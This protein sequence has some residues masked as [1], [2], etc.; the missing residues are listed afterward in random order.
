[1]CNA[2]LGLPPHAPSILI[3][4]GAIFLPRAYYAAWRV[5]YCIKPGALDELGTA[6]P[7]HPYIKDLIVG[8]AQLLARLKPANATTHHRDLL[9]EINIFIP[10]SHPICVHR[11]PQA[12]VSNSERLELLCP[13][14]FVLLI[15]SDTQRMNLPV[16]IDYEH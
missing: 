5:V 14:E 16:F 10:S 3:S 7:L 2:I 1:M 13:A 11:V 6:N 12:L 9:N 15:L 4:P 8:P